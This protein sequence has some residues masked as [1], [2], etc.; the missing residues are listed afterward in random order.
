MWSTGDTQ[1]I[2]MAAFEKERRSALCKWK[3]LPTAIIDLV[4][5]M[6][7]HQSSCQ[8]MYFLSKHGQLWTKQQWFSTNTSLFLLRIVDAILCLQSHEQR[9]VL[10]HLGPSLCDK[11]CPKFKSLWNEFEKL[12]REVSKDKWKK[13]WITFIE[14]N[15]KI[16]LSSLSS[17]SF[18]EKE[19][20]GN[21]LLAQKMSLIPIDNFQWEIDKWLKTTQGMPLL[22]RNQQNYLIPTEKI[23]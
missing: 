4:Y 20:W 7:M 10:V 23:K 12:F 3:R 1:L 2:N 14:T 18:L 21:Y 19:R 9:A 8:P 16:V 17:M 6:S 22:Q 15:E 13:A 11:L 5:E